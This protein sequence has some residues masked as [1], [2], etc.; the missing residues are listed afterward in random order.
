LLGW[1]DTTTKLVPLGSG[2]VMT[3]CVNGTGDL[4]NIYWSISAAGKI[5]RGETVTDGHVADTCPSRSKISGVIAWTPS[6]R[7]LNAQ[8]ALIPLLKLDE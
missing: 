6:P 8:C 7:V 5:T 2:N 4:Q 3:T 1:Q